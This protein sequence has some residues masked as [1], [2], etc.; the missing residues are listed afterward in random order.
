MDYSAGTSLML[1]KR[2]CCPQQLISITNNPDNLDCNFY[3]KAYKDVNPRFVKPFTHYYSIGKQEDRLPNEQAF[4]D[5]YPLC[6][7]S[8]YMR[9]NNDLAHF[10][11]EELMSHFHTRGRFECRAYK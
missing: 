6:D 4:K 3:I 10:T 9:Y 11:K 7:L 8:S 5:L 1:A 2:R